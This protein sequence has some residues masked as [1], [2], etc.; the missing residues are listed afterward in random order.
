MERVVAV[1][2]PAS[3]VERVDERAVDEFRTRASLVRA[4]VDEG[5]KRREAVEP[6]E[7]S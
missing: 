6:R 3:L 1:H 4:M 5:L 2:L 7:A